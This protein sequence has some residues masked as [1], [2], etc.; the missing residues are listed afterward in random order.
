[1]FTYVI[2]VL[3]SV[4]DIILAQR[5]SLYI[6][7]PEHAMYLLGD[8]IVYEVSYYLAWMPTVVLLSRICPRGTESMVY[9]LVAD[10]GNL[11]AS[12]S[13]TVGSLLIE[14]KWPTTTKGTG[15]FSNVPMLLLVG[16]ILLP[17]LIV[18]LS[19]VLVPA[20][21]I[22]DDMDVNGNT[23]MRQG[24]GHCTKRSTAK[25]GSQSASCTNKG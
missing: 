13:N 18:P 7:T 25:S 3:A 15:G 11:G 19:F 8:A 16:H 4:F 14:F 10:F 17:M 2:Q 23:I 12:L 1:M 5:W 9:A 21:R 22:C 20:A 24:G 6:G